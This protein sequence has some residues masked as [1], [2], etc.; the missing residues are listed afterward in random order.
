VKFVKNRPTLSTIAAVVAHSPIV[1]SPSV[2]P[3]FFPHGYER[4]D[5]EILEW[6]ATTTSAARGSMS[7]VN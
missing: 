6:I 2:H 7:F 5:I 1:V 3:C 4:I